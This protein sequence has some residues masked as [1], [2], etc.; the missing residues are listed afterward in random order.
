LSRDFGSPALTP[1][2]ES[3]LRLLVP[4]ITEWAGKSN[5]GGEVIVL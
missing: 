5:Q 3:Q 2:K 1:R 4:F